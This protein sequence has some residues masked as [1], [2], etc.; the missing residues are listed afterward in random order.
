MILASPE[1]TQLVL[2][3]VAVGDPIPAGFAFDGTNVAEL[4]AADEERI[5]DGGPVMPPDAEEPPTV[6]GTTTTTT[7]PAP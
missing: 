2:D 6:D 1:D 4:E 5:E 7:T 3:A